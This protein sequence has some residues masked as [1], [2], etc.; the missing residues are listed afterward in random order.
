MRTVAKL[1]AP[2]VNLLTASTRLVLRVLRISTT[3]ESTVTL[4]EVQTMLDQATQE[5]ILEAVEQEMVEG[6]FKLDDLQVGNLMTPRRHVVWL[7]VNDPADKIL[8]A[9]TES[10]RSRFPVVQENLDQAIGIVQA[11]DFVHLRNDMTT[12]DLRALLKP[13]LYFPESMSVLQALQQFKKTRIHFAFVI[14]EYGGVE[15]IIT[16]NDILEAIVGDIDGLDEP[17]PTGVVVRADGSWLLDGALSVERVKEVLDVDLLPGQMSYQ[18]LAGF[19]LSQLGAVPATGQSFTWDKFRFEVVDMDGRRV[20]QVL[21][22]V[23][24]PAEPQTD[25]TA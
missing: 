21:V 19:I 5:G 6:V 10:Q 8:R 1:S 16:P 11:K 2:V 9:F 22:Q 14:D 3:N 24:P 25:Q 20:D 17:Q 15:G 13:A 18:T 4:A 12:I 23:M 7:S